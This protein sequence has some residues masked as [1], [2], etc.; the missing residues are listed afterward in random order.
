MGKAKI[1]DRYSASDLPPA[2]N[3]FLY[4]CRCLI[5]L[6]H[7]GFF[8]LGSIIIGLL[9]FPVMRIFLHPKKRFQKHARNF[10]SL[11]FKFFTACMR[12]SGAEKHT[13]HDREKYRSL[14]SKV[15]VA[16]HP[17]LLDVVYLI[18]VIPNAD[19]I[20][21][22]SLTKTPF[23]TIIRQLYLVNTMGSEEMLE[24]A[25]ESLADGN[26]LIVF[27]EGTRTPRH[28]TNQFKRGASRIAFECDCDIQMIYIGGNDKYGLGKHDAFFSFNKNEPYHY[29]I[30]ILDEIKIA[31]YKR[32]EPQ[33]ASRRITEKIH[34]QIAGKAMEVDR[35][36]I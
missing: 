3:K 31:D 6:F 8:G 15:V 16:N 30:Y 22:G 2:K 35:R 33:I 13:F 34:E 28:G 19:C 11:S 9:I 32:L 1:D 5:K 12:A 23:V 7:I 24:L 27:P 26:N 17:S 20:V 36:I 4:A 10:I 21:R 25:K 29:D 14:K 18:S